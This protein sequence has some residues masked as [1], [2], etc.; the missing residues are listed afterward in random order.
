MEMLRTDRQI[1][2]HESARKASLQPGSAFP[3]L[4]GLPVLRRSADGR[5]DAL[6]VRAL[7]A[8][9]ERWRVCGPCRRVGA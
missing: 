1:E 8:N 6:H 3:H 2:I 4:R 5:R 7:A 9:V